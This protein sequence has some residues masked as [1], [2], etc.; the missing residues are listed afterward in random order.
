MYWLSF[1]SLGF[2]S[3]TLCALVLYGA[4]LIVRINT[5]RTTKEAVQV[6]YN[7]AHL[8]VLLTFFFSGAMGLIKC[9]NYCGCSGLPKPEYVIENI[10]EAILALSL[11]LFFTLLLM[12]FVS[13][14][15]KTWPVF[16]R[17]VVFQLVFISIDIGVGASL[18]I[19]VILEMCGGF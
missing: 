18:S 8:Q 14:A 1:R 9:F 12:T 15:T 16:S 19:L 13:L 7:W 4:T 6:F 3:I 17:A 10:V 5:G 2:A 11:N